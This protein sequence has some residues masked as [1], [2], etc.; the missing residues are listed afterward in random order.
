MDKKWFV[1][2]ALGAVA[3]VLVL[4]KRPERGPRPTMWDKMS[5]AMEEMP[6]DFPPRVMFEN[7]AATRSN[8]ERLLQILED[9]AG[10]VGQEGKGDQA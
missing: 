2:A 8:T 4:R 5:K 10:S 3:A 7:I 1:V 6:E 9:R